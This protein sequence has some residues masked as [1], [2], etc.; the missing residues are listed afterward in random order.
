MSQRPDQSVYHISTLNQL[1]KHV[2]DM[3]KIVEVMKFYLEMF[4][5]LKDKEN[6]SKGTELLL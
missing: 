1:L 6:G 5:Q 2:E 4:R 3:D